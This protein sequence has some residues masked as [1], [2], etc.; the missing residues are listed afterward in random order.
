MMKGG[1]SAR[2]GSGLGGLLYALGCCCAQWIHCRH[3]GVG[4]V[5]FVG[6]VGSG[7]ASCMAV[8]TAGRV[9]LRMRW[10]IVTGSSM[11]GGT[12]RFTGDV[13]G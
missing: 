7:C 1:G 11:T 13:A 6:L 2:A 9:G 5:E 12:L 3:K 10:N 8:E 4:T